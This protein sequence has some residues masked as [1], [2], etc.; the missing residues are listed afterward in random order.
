MKACI[1]DGCS[2]TICMQLHSLSSMQGCYIPHMSHTTYLPL[3]RHIMHCRRTWHC[4][5]LVV[6]IEEGLNLA[7][8][9][10]VA[11]SLEP[12]HCLSVAMHG[13][14]HPC[15]TLACTLH[16][17]CRADMQGANTQSAHAY[18]ID[19][20]P[21]SQSCL[22]QKFSRYK[23]NTKSSKVVACDRNMHR[24]SSD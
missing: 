8:D 21:Q 17:L 2:A 20:M 9:V 22:S 19:L 6:H 5:H 10:V 11:T 13:V 16:R 23:Q 14:T 7:A 1:C 3:L 4:A 12:C 24:S 18:L 15:H